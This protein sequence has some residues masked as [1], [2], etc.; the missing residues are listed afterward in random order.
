ML[1][2]TNAPTTHVVLPNTLTIGKLPAAGTLV[3]APAGSTTSN[4]SRI[5]IVSSNPSA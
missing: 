2:E 4:A 5:L 3:A 1:Q